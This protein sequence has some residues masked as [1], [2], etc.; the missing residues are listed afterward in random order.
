M[1]SGFTRLLG[2]AV[3]LTFA[4][5]W[6]YA[7][8]PKVPDG[9]SARLVASVPAVEYPCQVATA[10]GDVLFVAEDPM[11]QRGPYEAFDGRILKFKNEQDPVEYAKGFR[12]IQGMAWFNNSLYVCHMPFLSV[13]R[14]TDG[15]GKAP[16]WGLP[17]TRA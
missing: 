10:P 4:T 7:D 17:I 15:D 6:I 5:S 3:S 13:L 8:A 12:A 14:D 9:F 1:P 16:T 2:L 11:D